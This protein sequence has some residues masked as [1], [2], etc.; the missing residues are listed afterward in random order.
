MD[1]WNEIRTAAAVAR[2]GTIS[3]AAEVLG[4]HRAT[5]TRH[6]DALETALGA[7]LFQRHARGFTPTELGNELRRIA[8][9]T[10]A[11]FG[12]LRR[13]ARGAEDSLSGDATVTSVDVLVPFVLPILR[14]VQRRHPGLKLQMVTSDKVLKLE[15]GEADMAFR[16]GPKP[17]DPD[18]VVLHVGELEMGL[19]AAASF[20]EEHG[21]PE[22]PD[23]FRNHR[24]VGPDAAAP[25]TPWGAWLTAEI[26]EEAITLR[27]ST[28]WTLWQAVRAGLGIG[29]HPVSTA[30]DH[31]LQAVVPHRP[32]WAESIWA[33]T[34][35]DLH[36]TAKVQALVQAVREAR[37]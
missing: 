18:N 14:T 22:G 21:K 33:V 31:G 15:Y 8:D 37:S 30:A 36:R 10:D 9:G 12:E 34:H 28:V 20:S 16:V 19:Y 35:V 3:A 2:L 25:R 26:A 13:M 7:K 29:F 5:V 11:Q 4:V 24:F 27:S 23:S 6:I 1:D 17:T 32:E